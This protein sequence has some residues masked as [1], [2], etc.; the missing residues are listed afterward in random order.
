MHAA[1]HEVICLHIL[2]HEISS[3]GRKF[4]LRSITLNHYQPIVIIINNLPL[5]FWMVGFYSCI[6]FMAVFQKSDLTACYD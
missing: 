3:D 2:S 6:T 1:N 4:P 5:D